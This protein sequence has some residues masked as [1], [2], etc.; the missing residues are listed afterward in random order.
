[1]L[2]FDYL[3]SSHTKKVKNNLENFLIE[4]WSS[5]ASLSDNTEKEIK[6]IKSKTIKAVTASKGNKDKLVY[7]ATLLNKINPNYLD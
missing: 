6:N 3:Y 5:T 4:S 2:F 7:L 1:M